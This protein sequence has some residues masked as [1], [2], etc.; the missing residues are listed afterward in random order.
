MTTN[1]VADHGHD[2]MQTHVQIMMHPEQ[3][4]H[5][6]IH[7]DTLVS[8]LGCDPDSVS[9]CAAALS[10]DHMTITGANT[11]VDSHVLVTT[12][13]GD[14]IAGHSA[15]HIDSN[16]DVHGSHANLRQGN[17]RTGLNIKIPLQSSSITAEERK[18]KMTQDFTRNKNWKKHLGMKADELIKMSGA[19]VKHGVDADGNTHTR[20]LINEHDSPLGL[21]IK[22]NPKSD[23]PIMS[24]YNEGSVKRVGQ[25]VVMEKDHVDQLAETLATTLAPLSPISQHGLRIAIK[26]MHHAKTHLTEPTPAQIDFKIHRQPI[27]HIID[28]V[29]VG[30]RV[31]TTSEA[32]ALG[33]PGGD[34]KTSADKV[35]DMHDAIFGV[36]IGNKKP[37]KVT[38]APVEAPAAISAPAVV[39]EAAGSAHAEAA[40]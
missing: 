20:V 40:N 37:P 9:P 11:P 3:G 39:A 29:D 16:S 35:N 36:K 24:Q 18:E 5:V 7:P 14:M 2:E 26:P 33:T 30:G 8:M 13:K 15:N 4:G 38:A 12:I 34:S 27:K 1:A 10:M 6:D 22:M 19:E 28:G 32:S 17:I 23:H 21:L 25:K 31:L